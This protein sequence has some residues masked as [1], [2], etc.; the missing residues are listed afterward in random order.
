M[1]VQPGYLF[2]GFALFA[3]TAATT[4]AQAYLPLLMGVLGL[5]LWPWRNPRFR[6]PVWIG[7][8]L[9]MLAMSLAAQLGMNALRDAWQ[10]LENRLMQ[11]AAGGGLDQLR[12]FTAI[13]AVGELKRSSRIILRLETGDDG[14]PGLLR[15][16]AFNRF[17]NHTWSTGH[18]EFQTV[19]A[20]LEGVLWRLSGQRGGGSSMTISRYTTQGEA[21][22]ALP[23]S[24]LAIRDLAATTVETNYLAAAR[25]R[26]GPPLALY[27][28]E[29]GPGGGFDGAPEPDDLN[30][31]NLGAADRE[32]VGAVAKELG[33]SGLDPAR[34]VKAVERFFADG[35]TYSLWQGRLPERTNTSALAVFLRE[36]RAGH[37]EY[38]ATAT[39][40]LLRTAGVPTRYAVGYSPERRS[41]RLWLARGR[42]AH[43]WCLAHV[44]GR[45]SE[46]DT[47]P[48]TW[49]EREAAEAPWWEGLSDAF[50]QAWYRFAVWRQ[51]GGNWQLFVF[52]GSIAVLAWLGWRQLRGSRWRRATGSSLPTREF[53]PPP[54]LDS[55]FFAVIRRLESLHGP[56]PPHETLRAWLMRLPGVV[57]SEAR[58]LREALWFHYR[59]RF[60][61][62]GLAPADRARLRELAQQYLRDT[63]A[64][65]QPGRV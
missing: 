49:R 46:V 31:E 13:G 51:Q 48:G 41:G 1:R 8:L 28:V 9:A 37:C 5:A 18:R 21:P 6:A 24:P 25:V 22:L 30:W 33:L 61:P 62:A 59:L 39:T 4:H 12:S 47:T 43:A 3:S 15:E 65:P 56:R 11:R 27:T 29:H 32:V 26:D 64:V 36:T 38:F 53:Q 7:L 45:W 2:V 60:D 10:A 16:A 57:D 54:G 20:V 44:D 34:A 50:S 55:E 58:P 17:R 35:F 40:L 52:A 23:D 63:A 14:A 42:D 19:P